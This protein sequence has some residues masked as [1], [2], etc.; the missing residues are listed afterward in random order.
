MA[1]E[2]IEHLELIDGVEIAYARGDET[3]NTLIEVLSKP[4]RREMLKLLDGTKRAIDVRK[5]LNAR[6][7]HLT[8]QDVAYH[9]KQIH[10]LVPAIVDFWM[11][12]RSRYYRVK[13]PHVLL[14][15]KPSTFLA[16]LSNKVP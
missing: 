1:L 12:G 16:L 3:I 15:L 14:E 6:G 8:D 7:W 11:E 5:A 13:Q 9:L 4:V 2:T 10:R